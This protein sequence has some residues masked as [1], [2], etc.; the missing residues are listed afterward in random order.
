MHIWPWWL[1]N[2]HHIWLTVSI[3]VGHEL[4]PFGWYMGH[5]WA[6]Y[7]QHMNH[8][9][10]IWQKPVIYALS[11]GTYMRHIWWSFGT[12]MFLFSRAFFRFVPE[13]QVSNPEVRALLPLDLDITWPIDL[14]TCR[15]HLQPDHAPEDPVLHHQPHRA[16]RGHH[17]P[18]G[19][20]LLPAFSLRGKGAQRVLKTCTKQFQNFQQSR[21]NVSK[22]IQSKTRHTCFSLQAR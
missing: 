22:A 21:T 4:D 14:L 10:H 11:Y 8:V 3:Y 12:Y 20:R 7:G 16:L 18:H 2:G 5:I 15:Y 19:P 1:P 6:I 9:W 17:L 13:F